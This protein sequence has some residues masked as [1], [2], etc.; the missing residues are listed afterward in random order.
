MLE[1][2]TLANSGAIMAVITYIVCV[3]AVA[4]APEAAFNFF[5]L[6][7]HGVNAEVLR[8]ATVNLNLANVVLG[9]VFWVLLTWIVFYG[10]GYFY[11]SLKSK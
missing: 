10:F 3:I 1:T 5:A 2:K 8:P 9:G 4:I 6:T 11:N 7:F